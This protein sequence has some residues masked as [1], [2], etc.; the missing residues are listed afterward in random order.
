MYRKSKIFV[1]YTQ[2]AMCNMVLYVRSQNEMANKQTPVLLLYVWA[3]FFF[4]R[5]KKVGAAW[6]FYTES[7]VFCSLGM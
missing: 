6:D 5:K 3:D 7:D 2:L 4:E 1:K